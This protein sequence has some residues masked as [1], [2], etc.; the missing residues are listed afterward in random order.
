MSVDDGQP[1]RPPAVRRSMNAALGGEFSDEGTPE[2][3]QD[4]VDVDRAFALR[5]RVEGRLI[6]QPVQTGGESVEGFDEVFPSCHWNDECERSPPYESSADA[7]VIDDF[8]FEKYTEESRG[9]RF[10]AA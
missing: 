1:F 5:P 9:H 6:A 7:Q 2:K 3:S 10:P 8:P 4:E